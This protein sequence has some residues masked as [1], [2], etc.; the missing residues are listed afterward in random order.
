MN[1][2]YYYYKRKKKPGAVSSRAIKKA[3]RRFFVWFKATLRAKP[4][5]KN[6]DPVSHYG[7]VLRFSHKSIF[8]NA[9]AVHRTKTMYLLSA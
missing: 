8:E 3:A 2:G 6:I 7:A 1:L 9:V 5:L 4:R